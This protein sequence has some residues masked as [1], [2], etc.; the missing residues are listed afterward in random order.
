MS[1][2]FD[3]TRIVGTIEFQMSLL[4]FM[5]L[6]GY[7]LASR[8]HQSAVIGEILVGLIVGPSVLGW[9]HHTPFVE[10]IAHL[11]AVV[12]LFTVGLEFNFREIANF[13]YFVIALVGVI[14]PYIGG[15][16]VSKLWGYDFVECVF[17]GTAMTATSIA[18]TANVLQEMGQLR[19]E[20]AKAII[21]AAVIDDV[22][23]LLVLSVSNGV[24]A[25]EFS[26]TQ[27]L[28]ILAKAVVFIGVGA[29]LGHFVI[30]RI[31]VA[32]DKT[33]YAKQY[34]EVVFI[35][36]I[37]IA[38][39]YGIGAELMGLS[40]I[41]GAFL[42]G[43]LLGGIVLR[44]SRSYK[45]GAEYLQI[46]FAAIFF[47]NLG[48]LADLSGFTKNMVNFTLAL[49]LMA[50]V[51]KFLGCG[52]A[53]WIQR[54]SLRDSAI[55]GFGM[56]PRGEV[57]MIVALLGLTTKRIVDGQQVSI[58]SQNTYVALIAMSILTTM[59]TPIVLRKYF[60]NKPLKASR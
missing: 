56:S 43:A 7:L 21:G 39:L 15:Y 10:S 55:V 18:I 38:F 58:I 9:I 14:V 13:K 36:C 46:I 53:A 1:A 4:L 42:A 27:T 52:L 60:Y 20:A 28:I 49:T 51:S 8:I 33:S 59:V 30:R 41:V 54:M 3:F 50:V 34:P 44:R 16:W 48:I 45:E 40:A 6:G 35:F 23:G 2:M 17:V 12:M 31:I 37:M 11:G 47:L 32:I 26:Y 24:V 29:A 57:A 5:A 25:G 19:T 22:L